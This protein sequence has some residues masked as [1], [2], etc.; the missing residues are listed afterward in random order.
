M[1]EVRTLTIHGADRPRE[2]P[3]C[4][5]TFTP[6]RSDE[7]YFPVSVPSNH[8]TISGKS[9][10][11]ASVTA[12]TSA[13]TT[14]LPSRPEPW[15]TP[16][17]SPSAIQMALDT[18][19][20]KEINCKTCDRILAATSSLG[21]LVPAGTQANACDTCRK[22]EEL[23]DDMQT[24]D[25]AFKALEGRR[26]EHGGRQKAL[27][28]AKAAHIAFDNFLIQVEVL[29]AD[30][31]TD[32]QGEEQSGGH[33]PEHLQPENS[34]RG[35]KRPLEPSPATTPPRSLKR[36]RLVDN[37][38]R[39]SFESSVVFRDETER[40]PE[41]AFNRASEDYLPG[42]NAPPEGT[43]YVDTSGHG[44]AP[45]KFFGV[46][47]Q[48]KKWVETKEG[49]E[50][51]ERWRRASESEED[52][53]EV[54]EGETIESVQHGANSGQPEGAKRTPEETPTEQEEVGHSNKKAVEPLKDAEQ[55]KDTE[56][57]PEEL[58]SDEGAHHGNSDTAAGK[59]NG[60]ETD[61]KDKEGNQAPQAQDRGKT[62]ALKETTTEQSMDALPDRTGAVEAIVRE[63]ADEQSGAKA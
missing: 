41:M 12:T 7:S 52:R 59:L 16:P 27:E 31:T 9:E 56:R 55:P 1:I 8:S 48:G 61:A 32:E 54:E 17:A 10:E 15:N 4:S 37:S 14:T 57:G 3:A 45:T 42:R 23:H 22:F 50:E 36:P 58:P 62:G 43:E 26:F 20:P 38:R 39:V 29:V 46:R 60:T 53:E 51:D 47:K 33:D 44:I 24:K 11:S 19:I 63:E 30:S 5:T 35:P 25:E 21:D 49:R 28:E 13:S 6:I 40:R 18:P 34:S 2:E